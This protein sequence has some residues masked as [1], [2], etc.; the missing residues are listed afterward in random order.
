MRWALGS[1]LRFWRLVIALA[2]GLVLFGAAQHVYARDHFPTQ[3][4]YGPAPDPELRLITC[5]GVFDA[6][7]GSYL[8][9]VVVY[10]TQ[11]R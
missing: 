7:T 10:A 1:S 4:V 5:G 9:N 3:Q 6:A 11:I 2:I 8:S